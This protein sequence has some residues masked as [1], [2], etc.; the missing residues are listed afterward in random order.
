MESRVGCEKGTYNSLQH[1]DFSLLRV[2]ERTS[3]SYMD[4]DD[5]FP[6]K[7]FITCSGSNV[8]FS[9]LTFDFFLSSVN[10]Y[11]SQKGKQTPKFE[12]QNC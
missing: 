2:D 5:F 4:R 9:G 3:D 1:K 7:I 12:Q 8:L 11:C 6:R 10:F